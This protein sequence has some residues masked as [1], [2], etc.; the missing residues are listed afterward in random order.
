MLNPITAITTTIT[1]V[2]NARDDRQ[3]LAGRAPHQTPAGAQLALLAVCDEQGRP[4]A[5]VYVPDSLLL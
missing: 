3:L 2:I 1:D 4:L 5:G